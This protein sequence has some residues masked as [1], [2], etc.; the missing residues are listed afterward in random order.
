MLFN[1]YMKCI[2]KSIYGY[3]SNIRLDKL[4]KISKDDYKN[5]MINNIGLINIIIYL[6][7]FIKNIIKRIRIKNNYIYFINEIEYGQIKIKDLYL[8]KKLNLK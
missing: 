8:Y 3:E 7:L 6:K 2:F 5:L 4:I 1:I